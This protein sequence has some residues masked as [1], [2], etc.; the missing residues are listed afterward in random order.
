MKKIF[1]LSVF[2][3]LASC[4]KGI[5]QETISEVK[6]TKTFGSNEKK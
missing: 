2:L 3:M 1:F 6:K 5:S 4:N